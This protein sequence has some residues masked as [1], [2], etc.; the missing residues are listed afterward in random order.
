MLHNFLF[1]WWQARFIT[2]K[3][4]NVQGLKNEWYIIIHGGL[5]STW[6]NCPSDDKLSAN[7]SHA[8]TD[9]QDWNTDA[10]LLDSNSFVNNEFEN[11]QTTCSH[12]ISN[13]LVLYTFTFFNIFFHLSYWNP[14]KIMSGLLSPLC[15]H[16]LMYCE[17]TFPRNLHT[18]H[19]RKSINAQ[20]LLLYVANILPA[21]QCQKKFAIHIQSQNK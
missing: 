6:K 19:S 18:I 7:H 10:V 16:S 8:R 14:L 2:E 20:A 9:M 15:T 21:T 4:W 1:S 5:Y 3:I 12:K 13:I 17:I 11:M